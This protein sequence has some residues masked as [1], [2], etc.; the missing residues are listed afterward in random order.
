MG[1][2]WWRRLRLPLPPVRFAADYLYCRR[3]DTVTRLF[4]RAAFGTR[5]PS[6][7]NTSCVGA[8]APA[9]HSGIYALLVQVARCASGD[10]PATLWPRAPQSIS[11]FKAMNWTASI[12]HR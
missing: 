4:A 12:D 3:M 7:P 8:H 6:D 1:G 5:G 2:H 11:T 9:R 10:D